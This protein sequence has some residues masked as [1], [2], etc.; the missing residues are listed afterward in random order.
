[1]KKTPILIF[2]AGFLILLGSVAIFRI[3]ARKERDRAAA[4]IPG[5]VRINIDVPAGGGFMPQEYQAMQGQAI[6]LT[7]TSA[8]DAELHLH[9]YGLHAEL[10]AGQP[11]SIEFTADK[12][13]RFEFELEEQHTTLGVI[14]INPK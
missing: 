4:A 8:Q 7:V 11:G 6:N 2:I 10:K 5:T 9:G 3:E 12:T 13:G 14:N 1:M